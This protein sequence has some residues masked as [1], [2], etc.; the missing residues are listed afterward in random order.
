MTLTPLALPGCNLATGSSIRLLWLTIEDIDN[1]AAHMA[2]QYQVVVYRHFENG[3]DEKLEYPTQQEAEKIARDYVSGKMDEDGFQYDGA[4]VLDLQERQWVYVAGHFPVLEDGDG[5]LP[6]L[7]YKLDNKPVNAQQ[8]QPP[9]VRELYEKYKA[10]II[11]AL[12]NDQP[13]RNAC[14]N[15]DKENAYIEGGAAIERAVLAAGDDTLTRLYFDH[16]KFHNDLHREALDETYPLFSQP[17]QAL[18]EQAPPEQNND[19]PTS[20]RLTDLQKRAIEIAKQYEN[21]PMEE[22]LAI[23][24]QTFNCKSGKIETSLC[25]GKWRG[26]SDISIRFDNGTSLFIGN[27]STPKAKTLKVQSECVNKALVWYNPEIVRLTKETALEPLR[28][29][30]QKDNAAALEK[31]LKP[32]TLL[33]VETWAFTAAIFWNRPAAWAISSACC[34]IL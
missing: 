4:A 31:G 9:T 23:I 26:T 27:F 21:L 24:A 12:G 13:Y 34:R 22:R 28:K 1:Y 33:N 20:E 2:P 25:T 18:S 6:Y 10:E 8:E 19:T 30:E 7:P 11:T 5:E 29:Q 17:E 15:S 14:Q 16:T 3:F 32:Y